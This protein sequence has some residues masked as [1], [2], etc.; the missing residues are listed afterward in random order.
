MTVW[1]PLKYG[2]LTGKYIEGVPKDSRAAINQRI[3]N[4]RASQEGREINE[5]VKKLMPIAAE[6]GG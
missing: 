6:L 5:K 4:V 1:S 3:E 2:L